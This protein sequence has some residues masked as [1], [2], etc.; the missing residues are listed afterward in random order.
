[1]L[2]DIC[3]CLAS[4]GM[5]ILRSIHVA[6]NDIS[7]FFFYDWVI[8]RCRYI[9]HLLYLCGWTFR[10]LPCLAIENGA[11]MNFAVHV[12]FWIKNLLWIYIQEWGCRMVSLITGHSQ[13]GTPWP[14]PPAKVRSVRKS[15]QR[16]WDFKLRETQSDWQLSPFQW[17]NSECC[18]T[19][20]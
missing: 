5:I 17:Q 3:L 11:A 8:F 2:Y 18:T 14:G 6:A 15:P 19:A 4:L 9:P 20:V 7:S 13:V 10:L 16:N 1:M 12:S